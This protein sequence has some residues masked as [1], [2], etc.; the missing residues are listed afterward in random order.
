MAHVCLFQ[1]KPLALGNTLCNALSGLIPESEYHLSGFK[2]SV[3]KPCREFEEKLKTVCK[4][5]LVTVAT[6]TLHKNGPSGGSDGSTPLSLI[7]Q[8]IDNK[9]CENRRKSILNKA[10]TML[11]ADYHNIMYGTG[12][13][14]EDDVASAGHVG[15]AKAMMER[16]GASAMQALSFD[17]CQISL[18]AW[19]VLSL[20][21]DVMRE[22][23]KPPSSSSSL[24]SAHMLYSAARDCLELF[25]AVIP[26]K[27][28][29]LIESVPRMGAVFYNDCAYLAHNCTLITFKYRKEMKNLH[30]K[31]SNVNM[32]AGGKNTSES[33]SGA[34]ASGVG[35]MRDNIGFV[36]F[37][38]RL[39]TLGQ[40]CL[41]GHIER[42]KGVLLGYIEDIK[43]CPQGEGGDDIF[44][45][46]P[47]N[48]PVDKGRDHSL[49]ASGSLP[50]HHRSPEGA[51][52][53]GNAHGNINNDQGAVLVVKHLEQLQGQWHSV[54]PD[55]VYERIMGY[56]IE[57]VIRGA[58]QPV[59][60][61]DCIAATACTDIGRVFR[62]LMKS[63]E[64]LQLES[65]NSDNDSTGIGSALSL[66]FGSLS[67]LTNALGGSANNAS[68]NNSSGNSNPTL[69]ALI[70]SWNKFCV[71]TELL[72]FSISEVTEWLPR[73]KFTS[74]TA[75][76][77][78]ALIKAL[79]EDSVRR[80][81]ILNLILEMS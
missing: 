22:A 36:D 7:V 71:L 10:R 65:S 13:A 14:L 41:A 67:S 35:A 16:S 59:Q 4:F 53:S 69:H 47:N 62:I 76:E 28:E 5:P 24:H 56:L 37:I 25:I 81:N 73:K 66:G 32:T 19:R 68:S 63:R 1:N 15:D 3:E 50:S 18:A 44:H 45:N 11:L 72:D 80:Q 29:E 23:C 79:F 70:P 6:A 78:G 61:A 9:Y 33:G 74:F 49:V 30:S 58:V 51:D 31:I 75:Q 21:H 26:I 38:P 39:R 20:I 40:K 52:A 8:E 42:E 77:L 17:C 48:A 57:C 2:S 27:F 55:N 34:G 64:C 46:E 60:E 54:L 43:I 12:D